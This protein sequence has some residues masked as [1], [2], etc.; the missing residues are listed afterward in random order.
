M[1]STG[2]GKKYPLNNDVLNKEI[3]RTSPGNYALGK[4]S[5][6]GKFVVKYTGR[7][8]TD[9]K[10]RLKSHIGKYPFFKYQYATSPKSAF[11]KECHVYHDFG[12]S[13]NVIHPDR[14]NNTDWKCPCCSEFD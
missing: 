14:P 6:D 11:E 8:D 12:P 9:L 5:E 2:M 10:E 1:A 13:D 4:E 3:T 7:A